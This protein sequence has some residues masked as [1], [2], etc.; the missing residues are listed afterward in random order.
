MGDIAVE[1]SGVS[2]RFR[3]YHE[4]NQSLK[5]AFM[6]GGRAKYD[7]FWAL[8]DVGLQIPAGKTFGLIGHNGS[9]KS[10]LLKCLAGILVPDKGSIAVHGR[11]SALLELGAGFHPELSGRDNVYLNGSILGMSKKQ[12]DRSLDGIVAFA[13]LEEFIDTPVKNY[14]SGMYVR[15]GFSVAIN[16]D[17]EILMVDEVL[18]VGDESFQRKCMEKFADFRA[19]GRTVVIVSHALETMRTMCDEVAWLDHGVLKGVGRPQ[20][21]VDEYVGGTHEDRVGGSAG[22][23]RWGSGEVTIQSVELLSGGGPTSHVPTGADVTLRMHWTAEHPI[24]EPIFGIAVHTLEGVHVTGPNTRDI[25][26]STGTVSGEGHMD[27]RIP[28]LMLTPGTY[29]LTVAVFDK[30][31]VNAYDHRARVLRFDVAPG[32]PSER[33]GVV[34]LGGS[35]ELQTGTGTRS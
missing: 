22:G 29:E 30:N 31:H 20:D 21:L 32:R 4:R 13:G 25:G 24:E 3:L 28:Q 12:I 1:V 9:G 2:K 8:K 23:T 35:W 6:R 19:E 17:P 16:V 33:Y 7:E 10:T 26:L 18:A 5:A 27:L 11:V 15:L 14:S 34:S